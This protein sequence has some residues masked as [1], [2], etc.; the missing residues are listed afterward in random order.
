M[1][2]GCRRH[3]LP[4]HRTD[5]RTGHEVLTSDSNPSWPRPSS[6]LNSRHVQLSGG[7]CNQIVACDSSLWHSW[8][9]LYISF[10]FT[11]ILRM[12]SRKGKSLL[13]NAMLGS[14]DELVV[15]RP[16]CTDW[17]SSTV[18]I[19]V[20]GVNENEKESY[21]SVTLYVAD[22]KVAKSKKSKPQSSVVKL[23]W[24]ENNQVWIVL[25][26][27]SSLNAMFTS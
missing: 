26:L 17:S 8:W 22:I 18:D 24:K 5:L 19:E 4:D 1:G 13:L 9:H 12:A 25:W 23:E 10:H 21:Y 11:S 3:N 6:I 27:C 14:K 2:I 7:L 15:M 16:F 20:E